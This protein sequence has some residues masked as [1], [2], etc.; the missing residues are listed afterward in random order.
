LIKS[1]AAVDFNK[2][3]MTSTGWR[4]IADTSLSKLATAQQSYAGADRVLPKC[5][6]VEGDHWPIIT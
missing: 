3:S 4:I 2:K 1:R 6:K 5:G